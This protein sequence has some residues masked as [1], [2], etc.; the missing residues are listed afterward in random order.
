MTGATALLRGMGVVVLYG[1][2]PF[3]LGMTPFLVARDPG[4]LSPVMIAGALMGVSTLYSLRREW[5]AGPEG[6]PKFGMR[7]RLFLIMA[8][9]SSAV[10]IIAGMLIGWLIWSG[11]DEAAR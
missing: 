6:S 11:A 5:T 1:M 9:T 7:R 10:C 4:G 2:G 8:C 3:F